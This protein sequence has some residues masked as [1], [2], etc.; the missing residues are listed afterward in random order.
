MALPQ[1]DIDY[2]NKKGHR[3]SVSEEG[4]MTCVVLQGYNLPVGFNLESTDLLVRLTPGYPDIAPDMWWFE[5]AVHRADGKPIAATDHAEV[6]QGRNWQRW[7]RHLEPGQWTPGNDTLEA[8][9]AIM[10]VNLEQASVKE[11]L[12]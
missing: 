10:H 2:L 11:G 9:M 7:S 1:S 5:P 3:Y 8:Y 6:H 4:G 12:N